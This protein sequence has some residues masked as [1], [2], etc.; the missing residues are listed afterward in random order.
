MD[1]PTESAAVVKH[2]A[3]PLGAIIV[4]TQDRIASLA[5]VGEWVA[6]SGMFG[7][8][9]VEAG[10]M[11]AVQCVEEGLRISEWPRTYNLVNGRPSKRVHAA[12]AEFEHKGGTVEW[13]DL[14]RE[15]KRAAATL[16][17]PGKKPLAIEFTIDQAVR[18]QLVKSD[19]NWVKWPDRMLRAAVLREG[20][21]LLAPSIY[22]GC[23]DDTE[24]ATGPSLNLEPEKPAQATVATPAPA[25][26]PSPAAPRESKPP[27]VEAEIVSE[28]PRTPAP[29]TP[30][31]PAAPAATASPAKELPHD[32]QEQLLAIV[33]PEPANMAKAVAFCR[34]QRWIGAS[35]GLELLTEGKAREI[36]AR[37]DHFR[38]KVLGIGA[39]A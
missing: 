22:A 9:T 7:C 12:Q 33:G 38:T 24:V 35:D 37:K 23:Y 20:I 1:T 18:A 2:E 6:K 39:K 31:A 19:S 3:V 17:F 13:T 27:V 15:G 26:T 14:G 34:T 8:N 28:T 4:A 29:A 5:T 32:L 11:I 21:L 16:T 36:I 10:R 25:T 30:A